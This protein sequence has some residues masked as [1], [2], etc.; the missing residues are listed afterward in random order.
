MWS[1]VSLAVSCV[2]DTVKKSLLKATGP[3]L[4]GK[5]TRAHTVR[6]LYL[7]GRTLRPCRHPGPRSTLQ[8][9]TPG[10]R[11]PQGVCQEDADISKR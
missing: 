4:T 6:G 7:D 8:D 1:G 3:P 11:G 10:W 9:L 2:T 5:G